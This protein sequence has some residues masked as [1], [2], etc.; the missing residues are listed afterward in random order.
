MEYIQ[1]L[2]D[3]GKHEEVNEVLFCVGITLLNNVSV[4]SRK[5]DDASGKDIVTSIKAGLGTTCMVH[6]PLKLPKYS[7]KEQQDAIEKLRERLGPNH[8]DLCRK[9][10]AE[11]LE[12]QDPTVAG[13]EDIE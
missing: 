5:T 1:A 3:A 6:Q 9:R 10:K 4:L 8:M 12:D 7:S 2:R 11:V 13:V